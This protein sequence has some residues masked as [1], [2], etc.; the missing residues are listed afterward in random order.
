LS[1]KK[2]AI[3][4]F[5]YGAPTGLR[6]ALERPK[7]ITGIISQNGNAYVEGLGEAWAPIRALWTDPSPANRKFVV[8]NVLTAEG[9]YWQYTEGVPKELVPTLDPVSWTLDSAM[10]ELLGSRDLQTDI[11][12]DYQTNVDLYPRFHAYFRK[13]KPPMLAI[14]GDSDP[15]FLPAGAEAF[16]H[17]LPQA[18]VKL[19]R[20]GHF[21]LETHVVEMPRI[22]THFWVGL[23]SKVV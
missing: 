14:W 9:V 17:D 16:K 3:Y 7:A 15:L 11:F 2:F 1:L 19:Y 13:H 8:D 12:Q 18:T 20:A 10:L 21:A 4:I 22:S 23:Y 5:D 6:L